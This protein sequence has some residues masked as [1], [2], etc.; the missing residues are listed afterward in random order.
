MDDLYFG[1]A[2]FVF[3]VNKRGYVFQTVSDNRITFWPEGQKPVYDPYQVKG[4]NTSDCGSVV[5]NPIVLEEKFKN[6]KTNLIK[7]LKKLSLRPRRKINEGK[8]IETT[9][10]Y[11][12]GHETKIYGDVMIRCARIK[13]SQWRLVGLELTKRILNIANGNFKVISEHSKL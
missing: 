2:S 12:P 6:D 13:D 10:C 3:L 7:D 5:F 11:G 9:H 4:K 1:L 8:D